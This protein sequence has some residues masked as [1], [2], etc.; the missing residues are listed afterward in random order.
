MF[1]VSLRRMYILLL[2]EVILMFLFGSSFRL[3][4]KL[5][6][7]NSERSHVPFPQPPMTASYKTIRQWQGLEIDTST[8]LLTK[9]EFIWISA[10]SPYTEFFYLYILL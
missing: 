4:E 5:Q 10:T 8:K 3:A 1:H 2:D 9:P 7:S 6:K